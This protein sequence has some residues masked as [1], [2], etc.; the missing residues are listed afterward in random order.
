MT[1]DP[2]AAQRFYADLFG[3]K[4]VTE[5]AAGNPYTTFKVGEE[6]VAGMMM[7]PDAVPAEVPPYWS[8]YFNVADCAVIEKMVADMGGEVLLPLSVETVAVTDYIFWDFDP[9]GAWS[10]AVRYPFAADAGVDRPLFARMGG[11]GKDLFS[12]TG[13]TEDEPLFGQLVEHLLISSCSGTLPDNISIPF[14]TELMQGRY[15]LFVTAG[16]YARGVDILYS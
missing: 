14:E 15:D 16:D 2:V 11:A 10:L 8:V 4:A 7:M 9:V 1:R 3:W 6:M 5:P 12:T 13:A